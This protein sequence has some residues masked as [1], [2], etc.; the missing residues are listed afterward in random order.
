MSG[1][2][3]PELRHWLASLT[4]DSKVFAEIHE[5]GQVQ[6]TKV[7]W[8]GI[9]QLR[10]AGRKY[11][12]LAGDTFDGTI[13]RQTGMGRDSRGRTCVILPETTKPGKKRHA[14]KP[15]LNGVDHG[16]CE[17]DEPMSLKLHAA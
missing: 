3:S 7:E 17:T 5:P 1:K 8:S 10:R 15:D 14:A 6:R 4:S 9:I 11:I 2:L 16:V 12:E 13:S